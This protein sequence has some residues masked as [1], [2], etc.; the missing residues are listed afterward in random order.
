[1]LE[2]IP[3]G[4]TEPAECQRRRV[5]VL[6]FCHIKC[7]PGYRLVGE[8]ITECLQ[9]QKWSTKLP[10]CEPIVP[11]NG[12]VCPSDVYII[13]PKGKSSVPAVAPEIQ[14]TSNFK[15]IPDLKRFSFGNTRIK[16]IATSKETNEEVKCNYTVHIID[17]EKPTVSKCSKIMRNIAWQNKSKLCWH[18]PV[19]TDNTGIKRIIKNKKPGISN[20]RI[21]VQRIVYT[22]WDLQGNVAKCISRLQIKAAICPKLE[23]A[24]NNQLYCKYT[25]DNV[26][27][28]KAICKEGYVFPDQ[29]STKMFICDLITKKW[30]PPHIKL[31]ACIKM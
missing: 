12:V 17:K 26:Q 14:G 7:K 28:C 11:I 25:L 24:A 18:E 19:F 27:M 29:T 30:K 15:I 21:G 1:M 4:F 13:L 20:V 23:R 9:I 10:K 6:D 8:P 2:Q 22:A 16:V 31:M 3:N 5:H